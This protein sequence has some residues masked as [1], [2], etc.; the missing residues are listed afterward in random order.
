MAVLVVAILVVAFLPPRIAR[1][2]RLE[3]MPLLGRSANE[4]L[5]LVCQH[6]RHPNHVVAETSFA[7]G[8]NW[9]AHVAQMVVRAEVHRRREDGRALPRGR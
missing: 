2:V 5:E 4:V 7:R 6:L 3:E 1:P 9:S 8:R